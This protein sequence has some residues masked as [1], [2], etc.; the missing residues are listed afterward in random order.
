MERF[1]GAKTQADQFSVCSITE[2]VS[3]HL[4]TLCCGPESSMDCSLRQH[5]AAVNSC[6]GRSAVL[7][8]TM[9]EDREG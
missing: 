8:F 5:R 2:E 7:M 3:Y 4:S 6:A 9:S 1:H